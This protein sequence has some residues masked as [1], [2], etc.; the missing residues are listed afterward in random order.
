M[1]SG[2][3]REISG[4]AAAYVGNSW[5][6]VA[7]IGRYENAENH[8]LEEIIQDETLNHIQN[9]IESGQSGKYGD[10]YVAYF[11]DRL[12][13]QNILLVEGVRDIDGESLKL[14]DLFVRNI[15]IASENV[16]LH[17]DLDETQREII[18][19][20]GEAVEVRSHETGYH[21]RRVAEISRI[22]ATGLGLD[23]EEADLLKQASPLH[24]LGK[25][26][27][28]DAILNKQGKLTDDELCIMRSHAEIGHRML[29]GSKRQLLQAAANVAHQ[30]HERWD[31]AGYPQG[32][33]G[34]EIHLYGRITSVADVY[35][36]LLSPRCYKPAWPQERV[37]EYFRKERGGQFDP[38]IV[39]LLFSS[40]EQI[41]A[42]R[43]ALADP[44]HTS[45][46]HFQ[47]LV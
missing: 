8:D 31:G 26:G 13:N 20:L 41:D 12:G 2:A 18:F 47:R 10:N 38:K 30:H 3:E 33:K 46:A 7:G 16:C 45:E 17:A 9:A 36:A 39:D 4:V 14:M 40:L 15:S 44:P 24:D 27:V 29:Q 6:A 32:L 28:P 37:L 11:P 43:T 1:R 5:R 35:D 25:I 34:E 23:A 22:L 21:V 42:V 19:L